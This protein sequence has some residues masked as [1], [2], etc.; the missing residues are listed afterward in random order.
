MY[1]PR[2]VVC[3]LTDDVQDDI[4][5]MFAGNAVPSDIQEYAAT[6]MQ[7]EARD[8]IYSAMVVYGL[9]TYENGYVSIPNKELMDSFADMMKKEKS[10]GYIYSL[11]NISR[12]MLTAALSGDTDT[13]SEIFV[14]YPERKNADALILEL[15]VDS[16]SEDALSQ[17]RDKKYA[18]RFSGKLGKTKKYTG[19]IFGVGISYDKNTKKHI[20]K[21]EEIKQ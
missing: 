10:L 11:A 5:L 18:L 20:G 3:A 9:L 6:S 13:M 7:L 16:T 17:I 19:R 8:E 14:F 12:K 15:K 21:V 1:N 2:S 4:T